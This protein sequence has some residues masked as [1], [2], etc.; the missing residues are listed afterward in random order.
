MVRGKKGLRLIG[1][2][3]L[4]AFMGATVLPYWC[5]QVPASNP[6]VTDLL[7][8]LYSRHL[9]ERIDALDEIASDQ[10]LLHSRKI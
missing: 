10:A 5:Q 6:S 2:V 9:S 3:F 8:K 4:T 1:V 7:A